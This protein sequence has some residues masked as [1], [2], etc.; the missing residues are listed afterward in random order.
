MI[1]STGLCFT[2]W[3]VVNDATEIFVRL[4]SL[5]NERTVY[6]ASVV[7]ENED[8]DCAI[9]Q[10]AD[11]K[12]N[13]FFEIETD[14]TSFK[15]G[16]DVAIYGFPFGADLNENIMDLEPSLTKGYI[17]SKNQ[18]AGHQC[19]YLDIRS[20]P[21]NSGGPVFLLKSNRLIGYLCGSYGTD[22]ANIIYVRTMEYLIKNL[23]RD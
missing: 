23:V 8:E 9:L 10:L 2:C 1:T 16:D 7:Y 14:Y 4:D 22:R 3:H 15:S 11:C 13:P 17:S 12:G 5:K 20:A 6:E 18:I 19:Y 21:G